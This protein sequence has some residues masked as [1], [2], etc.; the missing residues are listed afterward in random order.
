MEKEQIVKIVSGWT[1]EAKTMLPKSPKEI[2]SFVE[3]GKAVIVTDE[4]GQVVGFGAQTF[5]WPGD[6]KELGAVI[7]DPSKRKQGFG[8]KVVGELVK[9]AK[10]N[11]GGKLFALC[12]EQSLSLFLK[13]GAEVISDP[14]EL[15]AEVWG[16]CN[17]CPKFQKAKSEGKLCCDTPVRIK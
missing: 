5:D 4:K 1:I 8:Y 7:V 17:N 2:E 10:S 14:N 9:K 6:W 16:E 13:H 15:P 11:G 12:N 3:N